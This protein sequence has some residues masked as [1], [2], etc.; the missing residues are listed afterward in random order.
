LGFESS[1][2]PARPDPLVIDP[3]D[4]TAAR[5]KVTSCSQNEKRRMNDHAQIG[6]QRL[7]V[8]REKNL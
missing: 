5:T 3:V 1:E 8:R 6:I 2:T 7:K 4:Y